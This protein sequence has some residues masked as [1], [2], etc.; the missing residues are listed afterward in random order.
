LYSISVAA[1]PLFHAGFFVTDDGE[2]MLIRFDFHQALVDG[3]FPVR[4]LGRLNFAYGYPAANFMYP[5]FMYLGE[6]FRLL[7]FGYVTTVKLI[8][9]ISLVGSGIFTYLWLRQRFSDFSSF[10]ASIIYVYAPYHLY[11]IYKRGSVGEVLALCVVPFVLWMLDRKNL[12]FTALGIA[13]LVLS[14]NTLAALFLP[15]III[16]YLLSQEKIMYFFLLKSV[17]L[18]LGVSSFFW[19][20]ALYDLQYTVFSQVDVS[21][22]TEYFQEAQSQYLSIFSIIFLGITVVTALASYSFVKQ[23]SKNIYY[24]AVLFFV[25]LLGVLVMNL[26]FSQALW[27]ILPISFIQFPF[28]LFSLEML[29]VSYLTCLVISLCKGKIQYVLAVALFILLSFPNFV[30][31]PH[32]K[33]MD[34]GDDYYATNDATTTVKNEYMPTWVKSPFFDQ[35]R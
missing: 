3:Q 33:Y 18:G 11:D 35:G 4:W 17:V 28:R 31:V 22:I 5:G 21:S 2:W 1:Y 34:K 27:K 8:L 12:F 16:Y 32:I 25:I 24:P 7:G 14:N 9:G 23:V 26:S 6:F 13:L 20:P 19:I 15:V 29:S 10:V 30:F